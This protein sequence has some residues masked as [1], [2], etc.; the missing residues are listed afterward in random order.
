MFVEPTSFEV[1][2][3]TANQ[4]DV[5]ISHVDGAVDVTLS[6]PNLVMA[7]NSLMVKGFLRGDSPSGPRSFRPRQTVL[8]ERGRMAL[9]MLL[10]IYADALTKAGLLDEERPIK[11][12]ER[13]KA[14][15]VPITAEQALLPARMA[16]EAFRK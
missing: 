14:R 10:G 3:L 11:V 12:L 8:T 9:G 1:N 13:I 16:V 15:A 7:R 5:L 4:R 6:D 2:Q